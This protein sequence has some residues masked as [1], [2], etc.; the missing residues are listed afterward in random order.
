M[1]GNERVDNAATAGPQSVDRGTNTVS[2]SGDYLSRL[3]DK[4]LN[5]T[6]LWLSVVGLPIL[7]LSLARIPT[8]GWRPVMGFQICV[9]ALLGLFW[10]QRHR[11]TY[12]W[13]LGFVLVLGGMTALSGFVQYGPAATSGQF[14]LLSMVISALFLD[15][16]EAFRVGLLILT[17]MLLTAWGAVSGLF[18]FQLDYP[19]YARSP[20]T[21][22]LIIVAMVG[23]GGA[24]ALLVW[25]LIQNLLEHQRE[26]VAANAEL[27]VLNAEAVAAT[28]AKS[29]FLATMSHEIRTPMNGILGM[30][31]L[32][33]IPGLQESEQREYANTILKSA[34]TLLVLLNDMLDLSRVESGKLVFERLAFQ[35]LQSIGEVQS[36]FGEEAHSKG[37]QLEWG[38]SV[39][40]GRC[41]VADVHRVQQ[42][43]SNLVSNAIKFTASGI[44]RIE[45]DEIESDEKSALLE[46]SVTDT[47][48]GVPEDLQPLLF[49]PFS[50]AEGSTARKFGGSGL[51]LSIVRELSQLMG[52]EV[53]LSSE[54]GKGSRFWFRI[55]AE[56]LDE[57]KDALRVER[58]AS[59]AASPA[60]LIGRIL[61][62]DD[63][64]SNRTVIAALL[65][66]MGVSV[67]VAEDGEQ[68]V[69]AVMRGDAI[70]LVLMDIQMPGMDGYAAARRIRKWESENKRPSVPIVAL[71]ADAF[72]ESRQ[73]TK[74]AGMDDFLTKPVD[75][76]QLRATIA[77]WVAAPATASTSA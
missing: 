37:I 28:V 75:F 74:T 72:E 29:S 25:R 27:A 59:P 18:E 31:Q 52:G 12:R 30:S 1:G 26:L 40:G 65:G 58:K 77:R 14:L 53:G 5:E 57:T 69:D 47:G 41:Y 54:V 2:T 15:G 17:C 32:L 76:D 61:I 24:V 11:I 16:R 7:A 64:P 19:R 50:Q 22:A 43:V 62:V 39:P 23:S 21:W 73:H 56:L 55:R 71:T 35:P 66:K 36:L 46:F 51:G 4:L 33:L 38:C 67:I 45:A 3:R 9:F 70:D 44:V 6:L 34:Q 20:I 49:N 60:K 13:R 42:M 48:I 68:G 8:T 10:F 63:S